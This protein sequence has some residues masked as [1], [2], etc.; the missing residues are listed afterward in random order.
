MDSMNCIY[1]ELENNHNEAH[2][3]LGENKNKAM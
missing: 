2:I 1:I 3:K